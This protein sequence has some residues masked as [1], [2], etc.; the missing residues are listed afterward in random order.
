MSQSLEQEMYYAIT[1]INPQACG[2]FV[3]VCGEDY[4]EVEDAAY[5]ILGTGLDIYSD[6][7]RKNLRVVSGRD[8]SR[9]GF[10]L[11]DTEGVAVLTAA[12]RKT[13]EKIISQISDNDMFPSMA[14][15]Y[16]E[17]FLGFPLISF[18][19]KTIYENSNVKSVNYATFEYYA[20]KKPIVRDITDNLREKLLRYLNTIGY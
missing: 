13:V 2:W 7:K 18:V 5:K 11:H 10:N 6:T 19:A 1:S 17:T 9:Y 4:S 16:N 8:L 15:V 14:K 20:A 3:I 12:H